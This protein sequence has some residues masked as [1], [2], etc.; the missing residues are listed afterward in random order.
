MNHLPAGLFSIALLVGSVTL[1]VVTD[2]AQAAAPAVSFGMTSAAA[3]DQAAAGVKPDYGTFWIGPWTLSS[4]WGYADDQMVK[5]KSAGVTPAIHFYYWGDDIT[6]TC[7]ENG[8]WSN[9]HNTH[10]DRAKW[11]QLGDQLGDHMKSKM[12]G[13]RVVVFLE[14][15]FNKGGISS[16]EPFDGYLADMAKRIKAKYPSAVI[17][18]GFGNWDSGKWGNFDRAAAASDLVG[19]QAMRGSTKDSSTAYNAVYDSTLSGVKTLQSLFRKPIMLTDVALSSYPEPGYLSMQRDNLQKFFTGM[20]ALQAAGVNS[21]IYRS[22][23]DTPTMDLA[24]YYGQAE[25]HWGLTWSDG[26]LKP[27]GKVWVDGVKAIRSGST[28]TTTTTSASGSGSFSAQF[29][30]ASGVNEW[31]VDVKVSSSSTVT[32]VDVKVNSGSWTGLSKTSYGTWAKSV[33]APQG[34]QVTFR[35]YDS[36]GNVAQSPTMSWLG[37]SSTTTSASSF[38]AKF[39]PASGVNEWWVDVKVSSSSSITKV[40]VKV[41]SGSWTGLSKTSYGTWAKSVHAAKGSQVTFRAYDSAGNIAHSPTMSWLGST[42]TTSSSTFGA[43]FTPKS[44]GNDWWV[45]TSVSSGTAISKVE[46]RLNG[47]SWA[48]LP[49]TSWGTYAKDLHAPDGT[50]VVFR[51][52]STSGSTATSPT[53]TWK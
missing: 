31:W 27:A 41:N 7:V 2:E 30:P 45:E 48:A 16:Y 1:F 33:H 32:K 51:A 44:V 9:L 49:K 12:Q 42:S 37:A 50:Q 28:T 34:S 25:R 10:K 53:Y 18:L 11:N 4:G 14:S 5:M 17:V 6:P 26:A 36:A 29:S 39:D 22:W 15:E 35:A 21:M 43:T 24:N 40:D 47:G 23:K 8:C 13:A 46:V 38:S 3:A 52:T 20:P 19:L